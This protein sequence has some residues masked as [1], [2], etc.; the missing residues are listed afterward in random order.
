MEPRLTPRWFSNFGVL[1]RILRRPHH[2]QDE[3]VQAMMRAG[4]QS[5]LADDVSTASAHPSFN[6]SVEN[7][8][9]AN[10]LMEA[11]ES[12]IP[13][14]MGRK[15]MHKGLSHENPLVVYYTLHALVAMP[16]R[17][18][19]F[20]EVCNLRVW[21]LHP[22][23]RPSSAPHQARPSCS[24]RRRTGHPPPRMVFQPRHH[25]TGHTTPTLQ[26]RGC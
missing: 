19:E 16:Y 7:S 1:L 26:L 15:H 13:R 11:L 23:R 12:A 14:C 20:L 5:L 21:S 6:P 8:S 3:R 4:F 24:P 22:L 9:S 10:V 18:G 25:P 17:F 2:V